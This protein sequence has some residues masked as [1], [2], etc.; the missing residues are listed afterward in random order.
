MEGAQVR[1]S[2]LLDLKEIIY[3]PGGKAPFSYA[4]DFSDLDFE[5]VEAAENTDFSGLVE[6]RAG[7]LTLTAKLTADLHCVCARCLTAF[8]RRF[9]MDVTA[10]IAEELQDEELEDT[11]LLE[12]NS[13]DLDEI[14]RTAFVLNMEPQLLC[15]EDC[16]GLCPKCGKNLNDGPCDCR[17]DQDPRLAVL[18]QLLEKD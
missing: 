8:S 9:D 18:G 3:V 5:S 4:P 14:A 2:M 17:E 7:A 12:G 15:R 11:Y 16:K 13:V 1:Y 6:N 10:F